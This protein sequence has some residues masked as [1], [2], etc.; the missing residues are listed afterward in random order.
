MCIVSSFLTF[1][2]NKNFHSAKAEDPTICGTIPH[3]TV[4]FTMR[5]KYLHISISP[6]PTENEFNYSMA[7]YKS[8]DLSGSSISSISGKISKN[9]STTVIDSLFVRDDGDFVLKYNFKIVGGL[10]EY[11]ESKS[12]NYKPSPSPVC[13]EAKLLDISVNLGSSSK[14]FS[15][16]VIPFSLKQSSD[17]DY[18]IGST[19]GAKTLEYNDYVYSYKVLYSLRDNINWKPFDFSG[20]SILVEHDEIQNVTVKTDMPAGDYYIRFVVDDLVR[21]CPNLQIEDFQFEVAGT[22]GVVIDT[23][24][25]SATQGD[26]V[27]ISAKFYGLSGNTFTIYVDGEQKVSNLAITSD[28]TPLPNPAYPWDTS[29]TQPGNHEILIKVFPGVNGANNHATTTS[30]T[31]NASGS[32][33]PGSN[34]SKFSLSK[35]NSF[36]IKQLLNRCGTSSLDSVLCMVETVIDWL[37]DIGAV[38]AFIMILYASAIYLTSYGDESKAELGKKTLIWSVIGVAVI[39]VA[40]AIMRIIENTLNNPSSLF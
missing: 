9:S 40:M 30:V 34:G 12:F 22:K 14:V 27:E 24:K 23:S 25:T 38:I 20:A 15:G 5:E 37:L 7:V 39:G 1:L 35:L 13:P 28:N 33:S 26:K 6:N 32:D 11:S 3:P 19:I 31:I 36:N 21:N 18:K 16:Q 4:D 10:C 8:S 2:P 17:T 29:G